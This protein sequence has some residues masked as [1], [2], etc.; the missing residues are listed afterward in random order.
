MSKFY[1]R[2]K[3]KYECRIKDCQMENYLRDVFDIDTDIIDFCE[4]CPFEN[5]VNK[6][7]MYED[8][9]RS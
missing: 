6:L 4:D 2:P 8:K 7:A 5:I 1:T 9:E 3:D